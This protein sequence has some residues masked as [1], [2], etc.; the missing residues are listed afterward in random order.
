MH[1]HRFSHQQGQAERPII[2]IALLSDS[3]QRHR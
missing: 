3:L 1:A 2:A